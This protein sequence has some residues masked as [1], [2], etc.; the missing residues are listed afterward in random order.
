MA[1][2]DFDHPLIFLIVITFG[3]IAIQALLAWLF[4][5]LGWT[6]PLGL[7]KGGACK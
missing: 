7:V 5:T 3:V 4:M 6:G 2:K 1:A